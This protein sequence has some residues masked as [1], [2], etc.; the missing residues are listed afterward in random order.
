LEYHCEPISSSRVLCIPGSR[1]R[2]CPTSC[3]LCTQ[4]T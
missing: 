4:S 3:W 2:Q 1:F